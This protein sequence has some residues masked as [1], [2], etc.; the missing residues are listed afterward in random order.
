MCWYARYPP[1]LSVKARVVVS[2]SSGSDTCMANIANAEKEATSL[3]L[4]TMDLGLLRK[5]D[6]LIDVGP[7]ALLYADD[8]K[9]RSWCVVATLTFETVPLLMGLV[10]C[11]DQLVPLLESNLR[12]SN[13]T[14]KRSWCEAVILAS[15][16]VPRPTSVGLTLSRIRENRAA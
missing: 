16:T 15:Q 12:L 7:A 6:S 8:L 5:S 4:K 9:Q 14:R 2:P 11:A 1:L 13:C 10:S 3:P